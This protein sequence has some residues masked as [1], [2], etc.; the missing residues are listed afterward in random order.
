M[1]LGLKGVRWVHTKGNNHGEREDFTDDNGL[2]G[3]A[4][5]VIEQ[6]SG[7]KWRG[8]GWPTQCL[9]PPLKITDRF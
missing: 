8:K 5:G 1:S 7:S 2:K 4:E 6:N 9:K 3:G